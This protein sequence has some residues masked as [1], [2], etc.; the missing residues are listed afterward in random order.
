MSQVRLAMELEVSQ[1]TISA[2]EIGKHYPSAAALLKMTALFNSSLDY[3][4]GLSDVR[5]L[6]NDKHLSSDEAKLISLYRNL[7][8]SHKEKAIAFMQGL[9]NS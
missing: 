2:Y 3:I 5:K 9:Y 4:M 7:S 6:M 8:V 1:E